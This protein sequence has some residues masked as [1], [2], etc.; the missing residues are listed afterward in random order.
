MSVNYNDLP[1]HLRAQVDSKLGTNQRQKSSTKR[2]VSGTCEGTCSCGEIF[3][4]YTRW[5]KHSDVTGHR[6]W[7]VT[8]PD[9]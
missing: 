1:A 8:L 6:R 2:T 4:K 3:T 5:E 9:V 7:S